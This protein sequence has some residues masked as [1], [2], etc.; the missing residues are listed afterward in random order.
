MSLWLDAFV[1]ALT[2]LRYDRTILSL[3]PQ[4][5]PGAQKLDYFRPTGPRPRFRFWRGLWFIDAI[6]FPRKAQWRGWWGRRVLY[7]LSVIGLFLMI[8]FYVGPHEFLFGTVMYPFHSTGDF[9]PVVEK[10]CMPIIRAMQAYS[11]DKGRLPDYAGELVP[12]YLPPGSYPAELFTYDSGGAF[13]EFK[14]VKGDHLLSY[15]FTPGSELWSV[16]G[17]VVNGTIHV[18][19]SLMPAAP[20][21]QPTTAPAPGG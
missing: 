3:E 10:E 21:T 2:S 16:S 7:Y 19:P 5:S 1:F 4:H 13:P 6:A 12:E 9:V 11:R 20:S 17:P 14:F 8:A 15:D 18:P